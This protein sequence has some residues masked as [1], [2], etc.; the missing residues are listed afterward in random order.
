MS[1]KNVVKHIEFKL[2]N[3]DHGNSS[4]CGKSKLETNF[5]KCSVMKETNFKY[6]A[7]C[8]LRIFMEI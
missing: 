6:F 2:F 3:Y 8:H 1:H 7:T 4:N 5:G